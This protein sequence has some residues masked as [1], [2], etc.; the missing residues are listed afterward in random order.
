M[1]IPALVD[2]TTTA[3]A[4]KV[5]QYARLGVKYVIFEP[6]FFIPIPDAD[7]I[8]PRLSIAPITP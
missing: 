3:A 5:A 8:S 4:E 1:G 7:V 2:I 6:T